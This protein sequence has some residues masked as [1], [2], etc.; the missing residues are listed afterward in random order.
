VAT[1]ESPPISVLPV[2]SQLSQVAQHFHSILYF[3]SPN[4]N[5]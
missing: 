1:V 4:Y 5:H 3:S 2:L